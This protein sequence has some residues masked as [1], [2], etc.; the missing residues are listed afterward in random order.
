M[1]FYPWWLRVAAA[2]HLIL[3]ALLG[4]CEALVRDP[5]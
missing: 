1:T 5:I 4:A 3:F 2:T